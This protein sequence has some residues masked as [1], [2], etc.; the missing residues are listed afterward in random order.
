MNYA[1]CLHNCI[2]NIHN[3]PFVFFSALVDINYVVDATLL[4]LCFI[5]ENWQRFYGIEM[6]ISKSKSN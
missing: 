2:N 6:T 3:F 1:V 4:F 5:C